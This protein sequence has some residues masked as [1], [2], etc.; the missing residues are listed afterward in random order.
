MASFNQ[1]PAGQSSLAF[2]SV[3]LELLGSAGG[4]LVAGVSATLSGAGAATLSFSGAVVASNT[5][6]AGIY[7]TFRRKNRIISSVAES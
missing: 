5:S 7:P 4:T 3:A 2:P 6:P 1:S